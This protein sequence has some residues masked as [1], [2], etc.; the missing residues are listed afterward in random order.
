MAF[1]QTPSGMVSIMDV[2]DRGRVLGCEG[3]LGGRRR[4]P[5]QVGALLG[6]VDILQCQ[7]GSR[8]GTSA[9]SDEEGADAKKEGA[10]SG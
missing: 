8:R 9:M 2:V 7:R 5:K 1:D 10:V 6:A 3:I 4:S